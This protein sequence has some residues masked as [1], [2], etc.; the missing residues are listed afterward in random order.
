M[1]RELSVALSTL[2]PM[3]KRLSVSRPG[4]YLVN[5]FLLERLLRDGVR[6]QLAVLPELN[7]QERGQEGEE[8]EE[9]QRQQLVLDHELA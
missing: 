3:K 7:S 2:P 5:S 8:E 4:Y 1:Q 6:Q 9:Q